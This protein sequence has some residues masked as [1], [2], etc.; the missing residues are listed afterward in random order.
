M[1]KLIIFL[2]ILPVFSLALNI[3]IPHNLVNYGVSKCFPVEKNTIG[4]SIKIFNPNLTIEDN[5]FKL[6]ANYESQTFLKKFNGDIFLESSIRFDR[7]TSNIYLYRIKLLKITDGKKEYLP[8][9][10]LIS[11]TLLS[12]IYPIIESKSIFNTK[13]HSL[14]KF[15]PIN[16]ISIVKNDL[17]IKF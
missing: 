13:E 9:D 6:K 12:S 8:N 5:K 7:D 14:T 17:L 10:N 15:L 3:K 1:K 11:K 16:D 4:N 2:F